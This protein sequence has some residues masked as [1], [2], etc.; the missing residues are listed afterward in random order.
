MK[1]EDDTL[2]NYSIER[3]LAEDQKKFVKEAVGK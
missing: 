3:L 1:T 2:Y